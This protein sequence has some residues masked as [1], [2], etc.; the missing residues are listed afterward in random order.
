[1]RKKLIKSQFNTNNKTIFHSRISGRYF[2]PRMRECFSWLRQ[3][4]PFLVF[5]TG[6]HYVSPCGVTNRSF[7][8]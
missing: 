6:L 1:M 4:N 7:R 3:C 5:F 2:L 8:P